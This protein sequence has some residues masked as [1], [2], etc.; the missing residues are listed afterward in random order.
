[1]PQNVS[2][3]IYINFYMN[4]KYFGLCCFVL[5][6]GE[7]PFCSMSNRQEHQ[8][9]R[10]WAWIAL[11][12]AWSMLQLFLGSFITSL[13]HVV[14]GET[15]LHRSKQKFGALRNYTAYKWAQGAACR[16]LSLLGTRC[17]GALC[18][19]LQTSF[20]LV[21]LSSSRAIQRTFAFLTFFFMLI[22]LTYLLVLLF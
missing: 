6:V 14:V 8:Q 12:V 22:L 17:S 18:H 10:V 9:D 11:P 5:R 7:I 21:P 4:Y 20:F 13:S 15:S 16:H 3:F 1:M 19:L 2:I